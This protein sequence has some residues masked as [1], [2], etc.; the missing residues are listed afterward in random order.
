M[1][2]LDVQTAQRLATAQRMNLN[3][4][5]MFLKCRRKQRPKITPGNI[6][7]ND[8]SGIE[9][10][11]EPDSVTTDKGLKSS[12]FNTIV[13]KSVC[14]TNFICN[15]Y[16]IDTVPRIHLVHIQLVLHTNSQGNIAAIFTI[17]RR[18]IMSSHVR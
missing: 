2:K 17:Y 18:S 10:N 5:G 13:S 4:V 9:I 16:I 15:K 3:I 6:F 8:E 12:S 14:R 7:N 1:M 11:N